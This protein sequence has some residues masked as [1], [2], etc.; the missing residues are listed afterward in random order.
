MLNGFANG[1]AGIGVIAIIGLIVWFVVNR[2][3]VRAN[4]QIR[5]LEA[6]LDEQKRQNQLLKKLT[7]SQQQPEKAAEGKEDEP[8]F[9]RV[10]PER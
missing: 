6:L 1:T 9:I 8:E 5:L 4:E 10:I 3:S 2:A 7:E